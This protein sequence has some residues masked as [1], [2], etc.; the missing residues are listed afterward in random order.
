MFYFVYLKPLYLL[1][2]HIAV[3]DG[4]MVG[5]RSTHGGSGEMRM[6]FCWGKVKGKRQILRLLNMAHVKL[7]LLCI[8]WMLCTIIYFQTRFNE[9]IF[10][11]GL[12]KTYKI[13]FTRRLLRWQ[14]QRI[15]NYGCDK[16][17][18]VELFRAYNMRVN[19][20]KLTVLKNGL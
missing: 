11:N 4:E 18:I 7:R 12:W 13:T 6:G 9:D 17:H 16:L 14:I 19:L 3:K 1:H 15:I 10:K 2:C 8:H 20:I 5:A